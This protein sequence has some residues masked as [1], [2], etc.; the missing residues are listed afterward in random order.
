MVVGA[1]MLFLELVGEDMLAST[2]DAAAVFSGTEI[3][4]QSKMH[5]LIWLLLRLVPVGDDKNI[6]AAA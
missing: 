6:I 3:V 5:F 2:V 1:Q 4:F